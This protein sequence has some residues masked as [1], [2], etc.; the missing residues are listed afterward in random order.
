M[1]KNTSNTIQKHHDRH[2]IEVRTSHQ[3]DDSI[4]VAREFFD[5]EFLRPLDYQGTLAD[6]LTQK[7]K[8]DSQD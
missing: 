2:T 7:I 4:E 6:N 1:K 3:K 5:D 8:N